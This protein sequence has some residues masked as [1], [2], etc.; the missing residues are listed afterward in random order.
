MQYYMHSWV[1]ANIFSACAF[2]TQGEKKYIYI[3]ITGYLKYPI[4]WK[5][6]VRTKVSRMA[7]VELTY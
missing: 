2:E 5:A 3:Y 1:I 4:Y 7:A 6:K